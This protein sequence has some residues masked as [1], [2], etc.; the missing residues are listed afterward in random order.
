M[1]NNKEL[2]QAASKLKL[3]CLTRPSCEG[4]SF[5]LEWPDRTDCAIN[6]EP[7][8]WSLQDVEYELAKED[9]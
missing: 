1:M 6:D 3:A 8:S 7:G 5:L 2:F 9:T 4:C